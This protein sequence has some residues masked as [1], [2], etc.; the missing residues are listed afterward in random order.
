MA[1]TESDEKT[2][3]L[4]IAIAAGFNDSSAMN[5]WFNRWGDKLTERYGKLPFRKLNTS[6]YEKYMELI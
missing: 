4:E 3:A 2:T 6:K 5:K 1:L